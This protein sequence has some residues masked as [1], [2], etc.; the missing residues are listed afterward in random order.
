MTVESLKPADRTDEDGFLRKTDPEV[1]RIAL[2][3]GSLFSF[4]TG[5]LSPEY[6]METVYALGRE[7]SLVETE[8]LRFAAACYRTER[9]ALRLTAR[10]EQYSFGIIR[11]LESRGHSAS[12]VR[13][14]VAS[15]SSEGVIDDSRYASRWI[16]SRLVRPS[17]ASP[18]VFTESLRSRG[19]SRSAVQSAL[20][21]VLDEEA[22]AA[23]LRSYLE[24][25]RRR[26]APR[27]RAAGQGRLKQVL[28]YE[29][30]S[31]D[32]LDR[33]QEEGLL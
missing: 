3:D 31:P 25:N 5:Y 26:P 14:V 28:R 27:F 29:G 30:F 10:A 8:A 33:F 22:E 9:A 17:G 2:S 13:A 19:L 24:K 15:L 11:K 16:Q 6:P 7:L 20:S 23:L 12:C 1:F 4:K 18:R 21:T 32:L